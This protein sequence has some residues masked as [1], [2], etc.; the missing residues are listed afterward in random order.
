[1]WSSYLYRLVDP[2][3]GWEGPGIFLQHVL[4]YLLE[5]RQVFGLQTCKCRAEET[6][7][8]LYDVSAIQKICLP[9]VIKKNYIIWIELLQ[10]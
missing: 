8:F 7:L 1:L 6:I 3:V 5:A 10:L 2:V 4:Q 9:A